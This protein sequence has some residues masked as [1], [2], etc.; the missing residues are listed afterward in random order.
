M[1][2]KAETEKRGAGSGLGPAQRVMDMWYEPL[3]EAIQVFGI[4]YIVYWN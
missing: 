3:M 1:K 4:V 2:Q